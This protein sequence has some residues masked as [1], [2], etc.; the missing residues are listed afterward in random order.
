MK[1]WHSNYL[2]KKSGFDNAINA[3]DA[4]KA[5]YYS[6]VPL[7]FLKPLVAWIRG[8]VIGLFP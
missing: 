4:I 3:V 2:K 7:K 1:K 8:K 5:T 6:N